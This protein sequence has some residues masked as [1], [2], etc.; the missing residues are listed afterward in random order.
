MEQALIG[1]VLIVGVKDKRAQGWLKRVTGWDFAE[2]VHS[3][4]W[5][6]LRKGPI[7]KQTIVD[8]RMKFKLSLAV[9]VGRCLDESFWWHGEFYADE[10]LAASVER[11]RKYAS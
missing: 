2:P 9:V 10:V 8:C 11:G 7:V 1:A 6:R 5:S 4:L 3:W